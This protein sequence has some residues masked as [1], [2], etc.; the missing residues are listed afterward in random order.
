MK[1]IFAVI[2]LLSSVNVYSLPKKKNKKNR[3]RVVK[4]ISQGSYEGRPL[5]KVIFSSGKAIEYM[6]MEEI[7]EGKSTGVWKYNEDLILK[8]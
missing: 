5:Y 4:I 8:K 6:Y 2:I 1:K 3:D 7:R